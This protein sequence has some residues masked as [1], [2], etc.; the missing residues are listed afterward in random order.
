MEQPHSTNQRFEPIILVIS[1]ACCVPQLAF[2]DQQAIKII[3]QALQEIGIT[4]QT[5]TLTISSALT[6]GIPMEILQAIGIAT[7]PSVIMR[8]PA[9]F[10]N[11]RLISFGVPDLQMIKNALNANQ[12]RPIT[13]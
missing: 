2:S 10:I 1:G 5:R 7:D 6:G 9:V 4:A 12:E 3:D 8:L 11:G 13:E